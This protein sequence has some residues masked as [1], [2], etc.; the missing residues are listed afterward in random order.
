MEKPLG[1]K[2]R[3]LYEPRGAT[4]TIKSGLLQKRWGAKRMSSEPPPGGGKAKGTCA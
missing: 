2:E 3:S 1:G 4:S